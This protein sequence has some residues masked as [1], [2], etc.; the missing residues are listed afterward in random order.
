MNKVYLLLFF[1]VSLT[2]TPFLTHAQNKSSEKKLDQIV[3]VVNDHIVLKSDVDQEVQQYLMQ[4]QQQQNQ[5]VSFSDDIWYT[6]LEN[7]I[8]RYVMLDQAKRDS[9]VVSDEMVDQQINQRINSFIDQVGSEQ[10]LEEQ[11]GQSIVQIRADLR[12]NYREQMVVQQFQQQK[13]NKVSITRPE[14]EEYFNKIPQDSLPQIPEQVAVSQIVA[15]PPPLQDARTQARELAKQLRDSVLNHDKTIEEMARK[16]S[17]G[18]SASSDGKLP[19][20]SLDDFVAEY[21]AAASAL[22][23][24]EISQVVETSFGFHVIRLNKRQGD[25]ID[26]NHILIEVGGESYDDQAAIDKLEQIR[27]SVLTNDDI[28]FAE[29]A[30]KH[31]EDPNTAPQGGRVLNPQ[32][33]ERLIAL[34]Q[35]DPALYRIVLLLAEVGDISEPKSF[36]MGE[37]NESQRAF[38]I[39]RLDRRIEEHRANLKQDYNRIKQAALQ[40]KQVEHMSKLLSKLRNKMYVE[41]K[42]S[43]PNNVSTDTEQMLPNESN[44][45]NTGTEAEVN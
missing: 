44:A 40:E 34:E 3:A 24:G 36:T 32:T 23:P 16:Y 8:D 26:T 20:M 2:L 29:M 15:V 12:D 17:D 6:V 4:L 5:R 25:Q 27:D 18:P 43:V 42:I 19:M 9:I 38:R 39:V 30:R 41:Y 11:M 7:I 28:T 22:E 37:E 35:L 13:R 1:V 45:N 31:S 10:A 14:V 21:S 33:G